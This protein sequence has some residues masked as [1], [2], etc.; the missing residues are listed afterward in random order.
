MT[1]RENLSG[2]RDRRA[3]TANDDADEI[4]ARLDQVHSERAKGLD[5][6]VRAAQARTIRLSGA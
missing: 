6:V 2:G 4:T 1:S 3:S 5:P